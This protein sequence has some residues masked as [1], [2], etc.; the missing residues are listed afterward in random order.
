MLFLYTCNEW[1]C[2]VKGSA[3]GKYTCKQKFK[4]ASLD[5]YNNA[6]IIHYFIRQENK[7]IFDAAK[8]TTANCEMGVKLHIL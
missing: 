1:F 2:G 4:N 5:P 8:T 6:I 3:A 7:Q